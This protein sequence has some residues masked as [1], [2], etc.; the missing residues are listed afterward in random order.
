LSVGLRSGLYFLVLSLTTVVFAVPLS[1][2]GWFLPFP[3]IGRAG[4]LWGRINLEALSL[5]CGLKYRIHGLNRLPAEPCIV[6]SKHQSAWETIA[7]RAILP[8]NHTWVIKRELLWTPFFGWAMAAYRPIAIDRSAGRRAVRQLLQEGKKW[9]EAGRWV[10]IFPEGTR[11][12]PGQRR[13]YG[14]GGA[15]LAE[16][17]GYPVLPV[18]HN[19]GVFWRRRDFRKYPGV[20][21]LVFG[22]LL[23]S[24]GLTAAEINCQV[25]EW[26]EGRVAELPRTREP[27][28][29]KD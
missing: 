2:L 6:L 21:D 3:V 25:E 23:P 8:P 7:L 5:I 20:V 19:A 12:A 4:Q 27:G 26:I 29:V 22:D 14:I 17:S 28:F 9:L 11:V 15:L 18:A 1:I 13:K 24:G 16:K 10:V